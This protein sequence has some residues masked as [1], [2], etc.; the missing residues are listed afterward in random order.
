MLCPGVGIVAIY[1]DSPVICVHSRYSGVPRIQRFG[2]TA[3]CNN[4]SRNDPARNVAGAR[5]IREE[6]ERKLTTE[7]I[8][9]E[10]KPH[11]RVFSSVNSRNADELERHGVDR[12]I[13]RSNSNRNTNQQRDELEFLRFREKAMRFYPVCIFLR[14]ERKLS[15]SFSRVS[16]L[17]RRRHRCCRRRLP[18]SV[19]PPRTS[20]SRADRHRDLSFSPFFFLSFTP[21]PLSTRRSAKFIFIVA[22]YSGDGARSIYLVLGESSQS[23]KRMARRLQLALR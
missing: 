7:G 11:R 18:T 17:Y 5:T 3:V 21:A 13:I 22:R 9:R 6:G 15:R 20:S 23:D 10:K 16:T 1:H 12:A 14:R 4:V 19:F 8:A 2:S